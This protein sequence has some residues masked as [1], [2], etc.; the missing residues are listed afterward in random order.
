MKSA[1]THVLRRESEFLQSGV[2][3]YQNL[4]ANL[5]EKS[6]DQS[7]SEHAVAT[8]AED[9]RRS[10][11]ALL[12]R[13][14]VAKQ[15]QKDFALARV[16][17]ASQMYEIKVC[18]TS[19]EQNLN[20]HF[21]NLSKL[22]DELQSIQA[23]LDHEGLLLS[24]FMKLNPINDTFHIWYS[25]PFA[26]IND[27]RLGRLPSHQLEWAETN[28]ALGD[29]AAAVYTIA[30][31]ARIQFKHFQIHPMGSFA[32]ISKVDNPRTIYNLFSDGSINFFSKT[33]FNSALSGF[34][35]CIDEIGEHVLLHD[36][37]LQLPYKIDTHEGK[38]N[39]HSISV[40]SGDDEQWSRALKYMLSDIKWIIAWSTKHLQQIK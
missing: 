7:S 22:N 33:T 9:I 29:A 4:L 28:A 12:E 16:N 18:S 35:C 31:V 5:E 36:P 38:I 40:S 10:K 2:Q 30:K 25:G 21:H 24:K 39:S 13:L 8:T 17:V 19:V 23:H 27:F 34:L 32:R 11:E 26:T 3:G 15:Q 37:T 14:R 1:S 6:R 20:S